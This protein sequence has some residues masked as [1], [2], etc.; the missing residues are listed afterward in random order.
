M[1]HKCANLFRYTHMQVR[2]IYQK[3]KCECLFAGTIPQQ[4]YKE[5]G[6]VS[7]LLYVVSVTE[8]RQNDNLVIK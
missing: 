7:V 8:S 2:D 1:Q 5:L 4:Y 3:I 6:P